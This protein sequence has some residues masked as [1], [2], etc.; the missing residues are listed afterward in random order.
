MMVRA[1]EG[2]HSENLIGDRADSEAIAGML[3][4][5]HNPYDSVSGI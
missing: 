1:S 4:I 2:I 3:A 5:N